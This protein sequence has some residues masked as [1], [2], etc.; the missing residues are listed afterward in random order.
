MAKKYPNVVKNT[1]GWQKLKKKMQA[2]NG[3]EAR[4]GWFTGQNYGP[5]NQN[6][7]IAMVAMWNEEGHDNGGI[8]AGTSTPPRPFIRTLFMKLRKSSAFRSLISRELRMYFAGQ[9]TSHQMMK[10]IG[11]FVREEMKET[12]AGWTTPPNRPSTVERKGFN[13]P[14][15]ETGLMGRSIAVKVLKGVKGRAAK[16]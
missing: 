7:P 12:I 5:E 8:F 10:T 13:N 9:K 6:L 4:A 15:V 1:K 16:R 3:M 2:L 14:L 11:N